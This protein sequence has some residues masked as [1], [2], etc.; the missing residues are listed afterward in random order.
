MC[1]NVFF[2]DEPIESRAFAERILR[3]RYGVAAPR[4]ERGVC[5]KPRLCGAPPFFSLAHTHGRIFLAVSGEEVGLDAEWRARPMPAALLPRLT[6]A[7]QKED[8]FRLW[9]A[10]EA[11]IKYC[12]GTLAR[13]L[14]RLR[15]EG[16]QLTKDGAPLPVHIAFYEAEHFILALC[17]ASPHTIDLVHG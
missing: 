2:T 17:T 16:G 8:F 14:P 13:L 10:K 12:G 11:Y 1:M 5:G 3:E 9:T 7:E 15:F 6:P 4:F